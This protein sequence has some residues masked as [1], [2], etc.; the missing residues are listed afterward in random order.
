MEEYL[1]AV[2][3]RKWG[4]QL[5]REKEAINQMIGKFLCS[6]YNFVLLQGISVFEIRETRENMREILII[7]GT[8]LRYRCHCGEK[9]SKDI[10]SA[11]FRDGVVIH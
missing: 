7:G 8:L 1:A 10:V 2:Y 5:T 6:L 4:G 3:Q 9:I 11:M